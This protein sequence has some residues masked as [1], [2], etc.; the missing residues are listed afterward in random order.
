MDRSPDF[1]IVVDLQRVQVVQDEGEEKPF[2]AE[3]E[4]TERGF[5]IGPGNKLPVACFQPI[6]A[7]LCLFQPQA[8]SE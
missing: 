8:L 5:R 1:R 4:I 2:R 3:A 6:S 7:T